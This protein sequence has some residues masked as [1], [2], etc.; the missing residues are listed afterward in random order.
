MPGDYT[1]HDEECRLY[2]DR[3]ENGAVSCGGKITSMTTED[4]IE[5]RYPFTAEKESYVFDGCDSDYDTIMHIEDVDGS[6]IA[7]NDDHDAK[8]TGTNTAASY[9]EADLTVGETYTFV[10]SG[11]G[12]ENYGS[13]NIAI[14]CSDKMCSNNHDL[15]VSLFAHPEWFGVK[16]C[17]SVV[18]FTKVNE[19]TCENFAQ[20]MFDSGLLNH[21]VDLGMKT[22][23][24]ICC[25]SCAG[26]DK[27]CADHNRDKLTCKAFEADFLCYWNG[28]SETCENITESQKSARSATQ[29]YEIIGSSGNFVLIFAI[30]GVASMLY[31][32]ATGA[33]KILFRKNEFQKIHEVEC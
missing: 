8:C 17:D 20:S 6:I 23:N 27:N 10:L 21:D 11:Y 29:E 15:A 18:A 26:K 28:D 1:T 16:D 9:F 7:G 19:M 5:V 22:L 14:T 33:Q 24:D 2:S 31:H 30:I 25:P 13:S 12:D 4:Q 3:M 32:T